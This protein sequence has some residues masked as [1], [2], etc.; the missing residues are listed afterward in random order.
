MD[1]GE[2][3]QVQRSIRA[4]GSEYVREALGLLFGLFE[5]LGGGGKK[6]TTT[7]VIY[8]RVCT[9]VRWEWYYDCLFRMLRRGSDGLVFF[10]FPE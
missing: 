3:M 8:G 1:Y 6:D 2:V 5:R 4:L 7:A 10:H 9:K